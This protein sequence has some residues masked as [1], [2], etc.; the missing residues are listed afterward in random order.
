MENGRMTFTPKRVGLAIA[1]LVLLL[2]LA[3][4]Q[5]RAAEER[6]RDEEIATA[7]GL[8]RVL[9]ATFAGRTDLK[10]SNI[11][12]TIDVTS[13]DRGPIFSSEQRATLPFS[14]DYYVDLS[15]VDA[16]DARYDPRSRTLT[17]E[18]PPVRIAEPNIDLTKGKVGTAEGFWV[19][20]RASADLIRRGLTLTKAQAEKTA[21]RPEHVERARVEARQRIQALLKLPLEAA[22][23]DDVS[24]AV[25]FAGE[26]GGDPSYLDASITYNEAM[27]EAR[28]RRAAEGR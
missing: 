19:S 28:R 14:V 9:T 27:E 23:L 3:A 10:V 22:G 25:R 20:R 21:A 5:W 2:L 6:R 13:V 11:S 18:V 15:K 8:A 16:D 7:E 1:A 26:P 4:W 24:V 17:V 12:G